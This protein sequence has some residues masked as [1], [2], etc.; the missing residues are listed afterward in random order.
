MKNQEIRELT[1]SDL[2]EHVKE[3]TLKLERLKMQ[4]SVTPLDRPVEITRQRRY[5]ARLMTILGEKET[6]ESLKK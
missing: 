1:I 5:V 4:H 3:E 6:N 2:R